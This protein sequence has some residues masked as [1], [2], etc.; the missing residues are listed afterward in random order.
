MRHLLRG[1]VAGL[2]SFAVLGVSLAHAKEIVRGVS[3]SENTIYIRSDGLACYFCAYGLE[4]FFKKTGRIA[5]FD[6]DMKA[7][8]VEV[9]PIEA[10]PLIG[11]GDLK[12]YVYDSGFTPRWVKMNLVGQLVQGDSGLLFEIR[13]TKE[14]VLVRNNEIA[15]KVL[16]EIFGQQVR[17][18]ALATELENGG[19][20]LEL[21]RY[22]AME[23]K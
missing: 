8:I 18:E 10:K 15:E 1:A 19:F 17:V 23:E 16:S 6:I 22:E 14:R 7:G 12:R 5:A 2:V 13:E 3:P 9:T 21:E 11:V 4:R 20:A